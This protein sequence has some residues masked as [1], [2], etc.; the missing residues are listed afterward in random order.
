MKRRILSIIISLIMLVTLLGGAS[1]GTAYAGE[2][3]TL[4]PSGAKKAGELVKQGDQV[5]FALKDDA[6]LVPLRS[7]IK[8][9]TALPVKYDLKTLQQVTE[10]KDQGKYGACWTFGALASMESG[11]IKAGR[12]NHQKIDLS[13][14]HLAWFTYNGKNSSTKSAY[15]GTDTFVSKDPYNT[16]GNCWLSAAT[17]ARRYGAVDESRA[18]YNGNSMGAVSSSLQTVSDIRLKSADILPQPAYNNSTA[19]AAIKTYLMNKGA[20]DVSYYS[21]END[22]NK[23]L[24]WNGE[25]SS[26]YYYGNNGAAKADHEVAIV[27]WDDTYSKANFKKTPAGNGAWIVKNSWGKDW[28]KDGYFYLS[29]YDTS[30]CDPAFYEAEAQTYNG[31]STKHTYSGTYQYDGVGYGDAGYIFS[32]KISAGN[33]YTARRDELLRAVGTYTMAANSTVDV[34]IYLNPSSTNPTSGIKKYSKSFKIPYAGYHTLDLGQSIGIPKGHTFSIVIT[35]S[36]VEGGHR[37][38][39]LPVE[40]EYYSKTYA[41]VSIDYRSG[42]SYV[43][44]RNSW[45]DVTRLAQF[46]DGNARYNIGNALAKGMGI[47]AGTASQVISV[48]RTSYTKTY[49][50]KAFNVGAKRT[51]GNGALL[52]KSSNA[53]VATVSSAGTVSIKGPGKATITITASPTSTYK[54]AARTVT[55]TVKPQKATIS[56]VKSKSRKTLYVKWKRNTKSSGYYVVIAKNKS[57]KSGKKSAFVTK[58]STTSKTFKKLS[59][60][61]NYYVKVR[62]YKTVSGKKIY[63]SYSSV[64][65]VKTR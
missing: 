1:L 33:R 44:Q 49:G 15:A 5:R 39:F 63:G 34:S 17:M 16:G 48:P 40:M 42:Q 8:S 62:A 25:T 58:N 57:F 35:S 20:V 54:S 53:S 56:S 29:Y 60:R 36:Y 47:G 55:V 30:I 2:K 12:A 65:R 10:V 61:K 50:N 43:N 23:S 31:G 21:A 37:Y 14:R 7:A 64:K 27:G 26:Q 22:N 38:Y 52:Y 9:A 46:R 3:V 45:N 59:S 41:L 4:D 6:M 18:K 19:K 24:Y 32:S 51:K 28:G 11:L 13:E